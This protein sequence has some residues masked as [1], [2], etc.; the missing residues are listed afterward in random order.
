[1]S[2]LI[3][4]TTYLYTEFLAPDF[5]I[6]FLSDTSRQAVHHC[7]GDHVY[8]NLGPSFFPQKAHYSKLC[9]LER[10]SPLLSFKDTPVWD[11]SAATIY[12]WLA[13]SYWAIYLVTK[14]GSFHLKLD[15]R[16]FSGSHSWAE[17]GG[18]WCKGSGWYR[19]LGH[20]L[21]QLPSALWRCCAQCQ[22]YHVQ[23]TMNCC[24]AFW[25]SDWERGVV[26]VESS[27]WWAAVSA[28][29]TWWSMLRWSVFS[30]TS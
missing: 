6:L 2:T 17:E 20:L 15:I 8:S 3:G 22:L 13:H 25:L 11:C 21:M 1:M 4:P 7:P 19:C 16:S 28:W 18:H 14:L 27:S 5:L 9:P 29:S 26:L 10:F 30:R 24:C 12:F 23:L